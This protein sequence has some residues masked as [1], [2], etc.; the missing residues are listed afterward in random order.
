MLTESETAIAR[1]RGDNFRQRPAKAQVEEISDT[2]VREVLMRPQN[3]RINEVRNRVVH[4][5][6]YRPRRA[7]VE[8]S[9]HEREVEPSL[10]GP[11]V[12]EVRYPQAIRSF[13]SEVAFDQ[14]RSG[15]D[16]LGA[17]AHC[18]TS[19][20]PWTFTPEQRGISHQPRYSLS[21][22]PHPECSQLEV[23]SRS[24]VG[25]AAISVD[26][27]YLLGKDGVGP[28]PCRWRSASATTSLTFR[29]QP[30]PIRELI[31]VRASHSKGEGNKRKGSGLLR[32]DPATRQKLLRRL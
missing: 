9:S 22:A 25:F 18:G 26:T 30:P 32:A 1:I 27:G 12:T 5:N 23:D 14:V 8:E 13:G 11:D 20:P 10:P 3:L 21:G 29:D 19:L 28:G 16:T 6:A 24:P 4:K 15:R 31:P 2:S 17:R 7:E